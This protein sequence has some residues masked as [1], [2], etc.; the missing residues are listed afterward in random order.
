MTSDTKELDVMAINKD[1]NTR[2]NLTIPKKQYELIKELAELDNRSA[3]SFMVSMI[4]EGLRLSPKAQ[5]LLDEL[6]ENNKA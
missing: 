1:K 6:N 5:L 4:L 3:N 2:I